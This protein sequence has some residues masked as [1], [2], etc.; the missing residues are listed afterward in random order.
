MR[1]KT[2]WNRMSTDVCVLCRCRRIAM[3]AQGRQRLVAAAGRMWPALMA[4]VLRGASPAGTT[5]EAM[6]KARTAWSSRLL[7]RL[8]KGDAGRGFRRAEETD[9]KL[10]RGLA[11]RRFVGDGECWQAAIR[12]SAA[13]RAMKD[14]GGLGTPA[15]ARGSDRNTN[16]SSIH[17]ATWQTAV[18]DRSGID[19][20]EK[21]P[22]PELG[23]GGTDG[24]VGA[25]LNR[26]A[27]GEDRATDFMSGIASYVEQFIGKV[28]AASSGGCRAANRCTSAGSSDVAQAALCVPLHLPRP[29]RRLK[30]LCVV[31]RCGN[32][33]WILSRN[34]VGR[35]LLRHRPSPGSPL[36]PTVC[37]PR[38]Q[39]ASMIWGK[40]QA[41][42][43]VI[44]ATVGWSSH[45]PSM[46]SR[47]RSQISGSFCRWEK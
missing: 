20:I 13:R 21:L 37:C 17:R 14:S 38:C 9:K 24:T 18:A 5:W 27:R 25:R 46:A 32:P 28:R 26:M 29:D 45:L 19:L 43:V 6:T 3:R 10:R 44:T 39:S 2:S 22:D 1:P 33:D 11:K 8:G 7:P 4:R 40:R 47:C 12:R 41:W 34:R 30:R 35:A 36:V 23:V 42:A 16:F 31:T 15:A